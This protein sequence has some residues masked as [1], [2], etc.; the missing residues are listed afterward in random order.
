MKITPVWWLVAGLAG[1]FNGCASS[2]KPVYDQS[3]VG[4]II[5]EQKGEIVAVRDVIIKP[6]DPLGTLR[7]GTGRQIGS[8]I[9]TAAVGGVT[10]AVER[11][12][13][14]VGGDIGAKMDEKA[15]EEITIRLQND[16][17]I[18]IVQERGE[19][20]LAVGERVKI[21]TSASA[22][23]SRIGIGVPMG[24][25]TA[26]VVRDTNFTNERDSWPTERMGRRV[27]DVVTR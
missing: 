17:E 24:G 19:T 26:R 21:Q 9:G 1:L 6:T 25:S 23:P 10:R 22:V 15:G 3:Q 16:E 8:A 7:G 11:I 5:R 2:S 20:P 14:V 12:G 4:R 18:V 27:A 13:S